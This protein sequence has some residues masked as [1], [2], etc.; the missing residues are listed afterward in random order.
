MRR[1]MRRMWVLTMLAV[2]VTAV[3]IGCENSQQTDE[4]LRVPPPTYAA[5]EP[6]PIDAS[7]GQTGDDQAQPLPEAPAAGP[8]PI[9][10]QSDS[11]TTSTYTIRKGDTLW[12]LAEQFYGDGQRWVD[13]R[14]ANP[15]LEPTNM[16]VGQEITLP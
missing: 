6:E 5:D 15:G 14:R 11:G 16:A 13:I 4:S 9:D 3:A 7:D 1:I 2:S 12:S 8:E 10:A